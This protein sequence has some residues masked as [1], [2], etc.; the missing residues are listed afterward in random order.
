MTQASVE[1]DGVSWID[2]TGGTT[3]PET[4]APMDSSNLTPAEVSFLSSEYF[5]FTQTSI[6]QWVATGIN[7]CGAFKRVWAE[8]Y[9]CYNLGREIICLLCFC[10]FTQFKKFNLERHMKNK[11][12]QM[13]SLNETARREILEQ[14]VARYIDHVSPENNVNNHSSAGTGDHRNHDVASEILAIGPIQVEGINVDPTQQHHT[15]QETSLHEAVKV[16]DNTGAPGTSK[17]ARDQH[18]SRPPDNIMV[19]LGEPD[20]EM[21]LVK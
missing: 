12:P 7:D 11:H 21:L 17:E 14:F 4:V 18:G 2:D 3:C 1:E 6:F 8:R 13:Y 16:E 5:R 19:E 15:N 10:R 20:S 9:L